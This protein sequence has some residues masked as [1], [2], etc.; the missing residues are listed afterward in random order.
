MDDLINV[1]KKE[2]FLLPDDSKINIIDLVRTLYSRYG[3]KF[4]RNAKMKKL[5]KLIPKKKHTLFILV[6]GMGSNI[7]DNLK[8]NYILRKHKVL[9][10]HT[11]CPTSTGCVLSSVASGMYP[12]THGMLGW[13]NHNREYDID[14]NTLLFSDRKNNVNLKKYNIY[15]KDIY[16]FDSKLNKLNVNTKVLF[17][18]EIMNSDYSKYIADDD[19]RVGY[20]DLEDA[21]NIVLDIIKSD[22]ETFTYLYIPSIDD[23]E[24]RD[25]IYDITVINELTKINKY[26]KKL[27]D[28]DE[29]CTVITADHGQINVH[30]DIIM[31]FDKYNKYFYAYPSIDL[32]TA[33]YYVKKKYR[34][35]FEEE[36]KKDFKDRMFLFNSKTFIRYN[37]FGKGLNK[38]LKKNI[39]EYISVCKNGY[40]FINDLNVEENIGITKGNHSGFSVGEMTI[41]LIIL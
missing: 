41:P 19:K 40:C 26:I 27:L 16:K 15:P 20:Y 12:I 37:I 30:E 5:D 7:I 18:K 3:V 23:I 36:F 38:E 22:E 6:D 8:S 13:Y 1:F 35:E 29:L 17:P 11:V 33:S 39:G 28:K 21:I 9:D 14:Y 34:K 25:G 24:H 31:D 10:M 4:K 32:G 2:N